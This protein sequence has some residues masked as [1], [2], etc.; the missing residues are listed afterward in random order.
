MKNAINNRIWLAAAGLIA[1]AV[2]WR[3]INHTYGIAPN[4]EI[5]TASILLATVFL[6]WRAAVAVAFGTLVLSD[7]LIGNSS[8]FV[9]TWSA[10][11]VVALGGLVLRRL[12]ERPAALVLGAVGAGVAT[13][14]WFF[15]W[16]NFGVWLLGDGAMYPHTLAG[17]SQSYL[18]GIPFYRTMLLGNVVLVPLYFA[19]AIYGPVLIHHITQ[20]WQRSR[21]VKA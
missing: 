1:T 15:V 17:L 16:T 21:S 19:A 8:I 4:L 20:V 11:A 3:V 7:L 18:M 13:S 5:V 9:F 6:G 14:V 10:F 2:A 12:R